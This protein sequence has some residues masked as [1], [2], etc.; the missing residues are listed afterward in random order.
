VIFDL[1]GT[2]IDYLGGAPSWP[3]ME[4]PGVRALHACLAAAGFPVEADPFCEG[5]VDSIERSWRSAIDGI[6]DPPTLAGLVAEVCTAAGFGLTDEVRQAAVTAYCAPIAE[7]AVVAERA[8]EVL[9]W[10]HG[11]G[12]RLGLISNTV[13]PADA[14]RRDLE[15][16][17]LL[18]YF[19]VTL[20]SSETGLW[21]PD[22]RVF[23]QALNA[24]RAGPRE[25]V[26]IG[27]QLA[28]DVGGAAQAGLSAILFGSLPQN[29]QGPEAERH[30][31]HGEIG[32]LT[33]LPGVL[34]KLF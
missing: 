20:F 7:H 1:G 2:L 6:G 22:R 31:P 12:V 9:A 23:L 17:G 4:L 29:V 8:S 3:A 33:E 14:H 11:N 5:F 21:K 27:D 25:A 18:E 30:R 32:C 16:Y 19:D 34:A 28:E 13:W 10:L 26:Y 15:R 24:L